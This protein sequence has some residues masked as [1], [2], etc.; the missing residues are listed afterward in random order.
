MDII[1]NFGQIKKERK[2]PLRSM[3]NGFNEQYVI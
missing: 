2:L 1:S 3:R